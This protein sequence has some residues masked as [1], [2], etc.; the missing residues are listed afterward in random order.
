MKN[1]LTHCLKAGHEYTPENTYMSPGGV[2]ACRTCMRANNKRWKRENPDKHNEVTR[3]SRRKW[4]AKNP[5]W[6]RSRELIREYGITLDF[7]E[8]MLRSQQGLCAI[9]K[10]EMTKPCVDHN[11]TTG[12]VRALLCSGCNTSLGHF[13]ES[14]EILLNAVAY[15]DKHEP[16]VVGV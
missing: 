14:R 10:V 6:S 5:T 3:R 13:R 9:C 4:L 7:Y 1:G 8:E 2:R 11:H 15:L 12:K 16:V